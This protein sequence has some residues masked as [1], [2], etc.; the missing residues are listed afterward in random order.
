M[1]ILFER[2]KPQLSH[3]SA[4]VNAERGE[5]EGLVC[6]D[7][8]RIADQQSRSVCHRIAGTRIARVLVCSLTNKQ[9]NLRTPGRLGALLVKRRAQRISR[10]LKT[11]LCGIIACSICFRDVPRRAKWPSYSKTLTYFKIVKLGSQTSGP[12]L[13]FFL[14]NWTQISKLF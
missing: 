13:G 1:I 12:H 8:A 14:A 7:R 2:H 4:D 5:R 9:T 10:L 11:K 3:L 6:L